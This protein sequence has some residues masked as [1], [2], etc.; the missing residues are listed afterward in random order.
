MIKRVILSYSAR[1]AFTYFALRLVTLNTPW[2]EGSWYVSLVAAAVSAAISPV[3]ARTLATLWKRG[4]YR[5]QTR[6][7]NKR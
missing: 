4:S 3:I 5:I 6:S 7:K 1:M 2:I